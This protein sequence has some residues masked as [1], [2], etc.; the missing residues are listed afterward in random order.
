MADYWEGIEKYTKPKSKE[1]DSLANQYRKL[2]TTC[3]SFASVTH[4]PVEL[5][6]HNMF[7]M[8]RN[9]RKQMEQID[10]VMEDNPDA[11]SSTEPH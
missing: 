8:M 7:M 9:T 6:Q 5:F 10:D 11:H 1:T 2:K 3:L 4:K